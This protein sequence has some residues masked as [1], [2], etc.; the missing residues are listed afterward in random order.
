MSHFAKINE[1]NM[2]TEVIVAD[3]DFIDTMEG[4]WVQTSYNTHEGIHYVADTD[5]PSSDQSLA[6]RKNYAGVGYTYDASRDAFIPP[7]EFE[8]WV[9]DEDKC[10]WE[11]PIPKPE[12]T[13]EESNNNY[14]YAWDEA[15]YIADTN[16]P[17]TEGWILRSLV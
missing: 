12:L 10:V 14:M 9:L 7:Q 6:L 8:S 13:E 16:N 4:T 2:V 5:T 15:T 17:K 11:A 1:D 3:Q